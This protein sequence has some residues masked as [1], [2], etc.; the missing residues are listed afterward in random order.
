[1]RQYHQAVFVMLGLSFISWKPVEESSLTNFPD[2]ANPQ[3]IGKLLVERFLEQTHSQYGS[4]LRIHEPRTQITYP[5]VCVW[6][7]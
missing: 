6:L 5:D 4:P 7:G 2:N 3:V 1:M